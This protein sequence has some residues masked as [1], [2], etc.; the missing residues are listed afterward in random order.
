M[1]MSKEKMDKELAIKGEGKA[2]ALKGKTEMH[3]VHHSAEY[4]SKCGEKVSTSTRHESGHR[5]SDHYK[6]DERYSNMVRGM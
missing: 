2:K 5:E 6:D 4:C 3:K 1:S